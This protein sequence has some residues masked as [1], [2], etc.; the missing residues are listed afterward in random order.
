MLLAIAVLVAIM[1]RP[2]QADRDAET[3]LRVGY[4]H[5]FIRFVE[6]PSDPNANKSQT[7]QIGVIGPDHFAK[8]VKGIEKER[9]K[10]AN[11]AVRHYVGFEDGK[12]GDPEWTK[13]LESLKA[14][15]VLI[16]AGDGWMRKA[17]LTELLASLNGSPIL[18]VGEGDDF[19]ERGGIINFRKQARQ[20]R[21]E[22]NLK[23]AVD[24]RLKINA[25]LLALA[26]RVVR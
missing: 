2:A 18:T 24:N 6:W 5:N 12:K 11:L 15:Q 1:S 23:S 10:N 4:A 3:R 21:F 8:I 13:G 19:L 14:C 17:H 7:I 22:I 25:K 20:L 26:V 9:A 16:I